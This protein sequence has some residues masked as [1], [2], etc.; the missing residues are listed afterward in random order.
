R[1]TAI[2]M[3][4]VVRRST[5]QIN[6][7]VIERIADENGNREHK[8]RNAITVERRMAFLLSAVLARDAALVAEIGIAALFLPRGRTNIAGIERGR[9]FFRPAAKNRVF[10]ERSAERRL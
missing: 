3:Q 5:A 10:S 4:R 6:K 7:A 8:R 2:A 1:E 9:Y